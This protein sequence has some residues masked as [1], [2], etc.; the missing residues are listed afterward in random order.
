M[1]SYPDVSGNTINGLGDGE[2][3]QP[4]YVYWGNKIPDDVAHGD[5][6]RWFY[7][8]D[9]GLDGYGVER[10]RRAAM[11]DAPLTPLA[12][13]AA[14]R[15]RGEFF[16]LHTG[17][18]VEAGD[19]DK[20][21]VA[22]FDPS[23]GLRRRRDRLQARGLGLPGATKSLSTG[24]RRRAGDHAPVPARGAGA[25]TVANWLRAQGW[26]AEPLTGPMSGKMTMIP[27]ALGQRLGRAGQ[28]RLPAVTARVRF[29]LPALGGTDRLPA[30]AIRAGGSRHR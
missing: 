21:G 12:E 20:I 6:Q 11:I 15:P 14:G 3:R 4:S 9:P 30:A 19:F 26:E 7:T 1:A 16:Q 2:R 17:F 13:D 22:A 25:I 23:L 10:A 27:A 18:G 8:V 28:A 29:L 24:A 5:D